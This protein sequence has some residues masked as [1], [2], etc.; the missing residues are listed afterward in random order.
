MW[1]KYT[2]SLIQSYSISICEYMCSGDLILQASVLCLCILL[3]G[4]PISPGVRGAQTQLCMLWIHPDMFLFKC[5]CQCLAI[6]LRNEIA[7]KAKR[8]ALMEKSASGGMHSLRFCIS[9]RKISACDL[10]NR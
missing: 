9:N 10:C 5:V 2:Q 6:C 4:T 1:P 7:V 3:A 8:S